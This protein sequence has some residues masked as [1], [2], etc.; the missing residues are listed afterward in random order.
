M[1]ESF[2]FSMNAMFLNAVFHNL[3]VAC[4]L[5]IYGNLK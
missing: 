3:H 2:N 5:T 4:T 1:K